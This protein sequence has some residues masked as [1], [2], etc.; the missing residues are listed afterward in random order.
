MQQ[1]VER[2]I[3]RRLRRCADSSPSLTCTSSSSTSLLLRSRC[4]SSRRSSS[5]S[6]LLLRCKCW[7]SKTS[8][9]LALPPKPCLP[10][11]QMIPNMWI[12]WS[13]HN[14]TWVGNYYKSQCKGKD[15]WLREQTKTPEALNSLSISP[16]PPPP[17]PPLIS[18][19]LFFIIS[20][21]LS[22]QVKGTW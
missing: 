13:P 9:K 12:N 10:L 5:T 4:W 16:P 15:N 8:I 7:S 3:S 18:F 20:L 2:P 1:V 11:L 14:F 6:L 21:S 19:S 17:S 22:F